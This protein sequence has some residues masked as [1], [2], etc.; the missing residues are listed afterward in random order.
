M[1]HRLT[2]ENGAPLDSALTDSRGWYRLRVAGPDSAAIYVVSVLHRG[3]AYFAAP[4]RATRQGEIR[5]DPITV[6]DTSS[7]DPPIELTE[8]HLIVRRPQDRQGRRVLEI[9]MLANRGGLTRIAP[10]TSRPVWQMELPR[11]AVGLE[12]RE[13][14]LGYETV[15]RRGNSVAV[16]APIPPGQKQVLLSYFLP[17]DQLELRLDQ[18]VQRFNVLV[19]DST[20]HLVAGPLQSLGIQELHGIEFAQF[21]GDGLA[22][23]SE[24][25]L[26]MSGGGG[27]PAAWWWL[28]VALAGAA[29][30]TVLLRRWPVNR[31]SPHSLEAQLQ[32]IE[33]AL[34]QSPDKLAPAEIEAYRKRKAQLE[35]LL[36]RSAEAPS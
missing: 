32:A 34:A 27:S 11:G 5:L 4:I 24:V 29:L 3:V 14:D 22:P 9:L 20:A 10:D 31:A 2:T 18:P 33:S 1:L 17:G 35:K 19:E 8:R 23:G 26:R 13:S 15:Y 28:V 7:V 36:R 21:L 30:L 16:A 6:Y 12:M 25:I